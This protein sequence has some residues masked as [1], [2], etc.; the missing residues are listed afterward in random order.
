MPNF[1]TINK[2]SASG[3]IDKYESFDTVEAANSRVIELHALGYLDAFAIPRPTEEIDWLI[4]DK[5][6]KTV[7][8]DAPRKAAEELAL[9]WEAIR[10]KRDRLLDEHDKRVAQ[11][12]RHSRTG[13][14]QPSTIAT[15]DAYAN[16]LADITTDY[17]APGDVVWP[18]PPV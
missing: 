4:A 10:S 15:L 8:V 17:P 18:T 6:A 5:V 14:G 9:G 13:R 2:I 12:A 11:H 16:A 1:I 3:R 7:T